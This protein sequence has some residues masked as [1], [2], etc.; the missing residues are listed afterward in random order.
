VKLLIAWQVWDNYYDLRLGS[1]IAFKQNSEL[2]IFERLNIVSQGGYINPPSKVDSKYIDKH[3]NI[4]I[5]EK[6]RYIDL[7]IKFKGSL[8]VLNGI[9]NAYKHALSIGADYALVTNA[10]A[11]CLDLTKLKKLL[12]KDSVI[13]SAI[14]A[15]VGRISGLEINWGD[16]VPSF[17]DHFLILNISVCR[18]NRIFEK[19]LM[20]YHEPLFGEYGGIHYFLYA[21]MDELVPEGL[22]NVYTD[23]T[24]CS[25]HYG[26]NSGY[27]LLPWQYQPS[28]GFL[29][30]NC[31]QEP[32]LHYL[33]VKT[34]EH[35][36]LDK[37]PEVKKYCMKYSCNNN[38]FVIKNQMPVFKLTWI[39]KFK[40]YPPFILYDLLRD[41][42]LSLK[43][44]KYNILKYKISN[45]GLHQ[46]YNYNKARRV[47][48]LLLTGRRPK[49]I[50]PL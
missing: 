33:R 22:F 44:K 38:E 9:S 30:A 12:N 35:L 24:D 26:E 11:W 47:K 48:S 2:H 31:F 20:K 10:D 37:Y 40:I 36:H 25:N 17:D 13:E 50:I 1:E 42:L 4:E 19:D 8:R 45:K 49:K 21:M 18:E 5:N 3:F 43:Y 27:N 32:V 7:H 41:V 6:N 46:T 34:L 39:E 14:S 15:R 16:Y 28:F 23:M 29:H